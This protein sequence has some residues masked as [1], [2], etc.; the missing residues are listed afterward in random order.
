M[1]AIETFALV[2]EKKK[3]TE[4]QYLHLPVLDLD[5]HLEFWFSKSSNHKCPY[6]G[7][8]INSWSLMEIIYILSAH[9][10]AD[11]KSKTAA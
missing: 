6:R 5:K 10:V 8:L 1:L 7:V 11:G 3:K 2:W 4:T 9:A